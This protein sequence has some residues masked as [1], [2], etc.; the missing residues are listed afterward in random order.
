MRI[1]SVLSILFFVSIFTAPVVSAEK[2][3]A[4]SAFNEV[5]AESVETAFKDLAPHPRLL[6]TP[7][8][9]REVDKKIKQDP[10]WSAYYNALKASGDSLM[11]RS[12]LKFEK[13]GIRLLGVS[14]NA[15]ERLFLWSFLYNYTKDFRYAERAEKEMLALAAF[16]GWN[17]SHYLDVAE[18]TTAMAIGYDSF[19]DVLSESTKKTVRNAIINF[20]I[21]TSFP[22]EKMWWIKN[23][24]NWNQVC[25]CGICYGA[26]ALAEDEPELA[27]QIVRRSVNGVTWSMNSYEPDGNY[28]EGPGYWGYGTS[29]NILLI[30]GLKS[31]LGTDFG[32][33]NAPGLLKTIHYYEHVFGTTGNAYN[34]PDSGGG[35]VFEPTVFWFAEHLKEPG[36]AYNE[37][38]FLRKALAGQK[39]NSRTPY[40]FNRIVRNRLAVTAL[41]W[42]PVEKAQ[43]ADELLNRPSGINAPRE[44]GYIGIGNGHCPVALLR[45]SW[46]ED[47]A[48][49]G[50]KAGSPSSPH[51]HM[52]SGSFVFDN[53]GYR[54]VVDLG[55]E[56]YHKIE[57]LGMNLW[58]SA[59]NSDRWK[60]F[61]YNNRSHSTLTI[62]NS[63]Q[64]A[65]GEA[66]FTETK[67][68]QNGKPHQVVIDLTPVYA[69][70]IR[71]ATRKA[72]LTDQGVLTI[73]DTIVALDKKNAEI[74]W[75]LPTPAKIDL[76]KKDSALLTQ[77]RKEGTNSRS[78]RLTAQC[79]YPFEIKTEAAETD[80]KYD[81]K[82]PGITILILSTKIPA[83][84]KAEIKV[85]LQSET[86]G[87]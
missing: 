38:L 68:G 46:N 1:F 25:H 80:K 78:I 34:Y 84:Q 8:K 85:T 42:G 62:N 26:L 61:R 12:P 71:S 15:L 40:S 55:P 64:I 27:R 82:N 86:G 48:Y 63:D 77:S 23:N 37:N 35:I 17:P 32:R 67:I 60:L 19:Y 58:S 6:M 41:L 50:I 11:K 5:T 20:G 70:E 28:T 43:S 30:A 9:L 52:D 45:S 7:S 57:Q 33:S 56:S 66:A 3:Q 24:A 21:K 44:L 65:V 14:R 87:R 75:R 47:G 76:D 79:S 31:A 2:R 22:S 54:W 74:Q 4:H 18:M 36:I 69:K 29:F 83:G 53:L 73:T 81:A 39:E 51:G 49:L 10:R 72:V 59:Q 16:P 13:E